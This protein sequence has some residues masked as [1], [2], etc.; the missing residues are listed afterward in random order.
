MWDYA[1]EG[2]DLTMGHAFNAAE[3][4]WV[5]EGPGRIGRRYLKVRYVED[6]DSAFAT[7]RPVA[8]EWAYAGLLGPVRCHVND[9][10][11]AGMTAR[12]EVRPAARPGA[13]R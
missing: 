3:S 6:T 4:T 10:A 5:G 12:Y 2:R 8:P 9:H 13:R 1:P 7:P 11:D